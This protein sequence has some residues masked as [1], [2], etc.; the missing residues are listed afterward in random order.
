MIIH[1]MI[2]PGLAINELI[3]GQRIPKTSL[4]DR[5]SN[6]PRIERT[7]VPCPYCEK[8]HDGRTWSTRKNLGFKN[9]FGLYCNNCGNI[10]PCLMNIFSLII[11]A[12]TF[13]IWSWF[14]NSLKD[15]WLKRQPE[16]FANIDLNE[17]K[18]PY[19]GR[20]WLQQGLRFGFFMYVFMIILFPLISKK[21]IPSKDLLIGI[22]IWLIGG[23]VF[24]YTMKLFMNKKGKN[25]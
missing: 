22:P 5:E 16:R 6:K 20:V 2:N 9:W 18:N 8:M 17:L 14:K 11:L 1:W 15:K 21:E 12:I 23:L 10:I 13:P 4:E 3:L 24:G 7:F 25:L 19:E